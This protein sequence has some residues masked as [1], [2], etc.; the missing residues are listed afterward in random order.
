MSS[1]AL[2]ED[3]TK[4]TD[5]K[6]LCIW[7]FHVEV[8]HMAAISADDQF[9][10]ELPWGEPEWVQGRLIQLKLGVHPVEK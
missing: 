5:I 6:P 8:G 3:K 10:Q 9:S 4:P 2:K 7:N 1:S